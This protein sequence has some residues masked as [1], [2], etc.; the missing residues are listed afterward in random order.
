MTYTVEQILNSDKDQW[1]VPRK[2]IDQ[3]LKNHH[4]DPIEYQGKNNIQDLILF[5][6]Y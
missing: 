4:I 2:T 3:I 6:G 1:N 5:L